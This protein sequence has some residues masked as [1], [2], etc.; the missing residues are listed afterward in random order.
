MPRYLAQQIQKDLS[1]K[2]VFVSGP[3]QVGKTTL[4]LSLLQ[5]K[6]GY[7]NWDT[8]DG[9][10]A[11]L[12]N[13]FPDAPRLVFDEIHKF[14]RWRNYLKGI[15]DQTSRKFEILVTGSARLDLFRRG[16]DSL[17]GRYHH[18][19]LFPLSFAELKCKGAADLQQLLHLA[20]LCKTHPQSERE[21]FLL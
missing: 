10:R 3:R 5:D 2:M 1:K 18:L 15:Y 17:Q 6:S 14:A 13:Q 16:V 20:G 4:A 9:R 12:S 11:I 7:L 8:D 21:R 19:T